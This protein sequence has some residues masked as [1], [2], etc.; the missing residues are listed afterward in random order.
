MEPP[1]T[2]F[3]LGARVPTDVQGLV[4]AT[5]KLDEV[6]LQ[7]FVPECVVDWILRGGTTGIW[8]FYEEAFPFLV[9]G[10][11][12]IEVRELHVVEVSQD[13]LGVGLLHGEVVIAPM[14]LLSL[15]LVA[16]GTALGADERGYSRRFG[17]ILA[18]RVCLAVTGLKD[19]K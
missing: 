8:C 1:L 10:G 14:P 11:F 16:F 6:L 9:E 13:R 3:F 19:N 17:L 4:A 7:W 15:G 18:I 2:A 12:H 5:R